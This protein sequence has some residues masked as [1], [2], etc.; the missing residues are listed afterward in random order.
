M[1]EIAIVTKIVKNTITVT[2]GVGVKVSS[3]GELEV[4][5]AAAGD[6]AY[7]V[8][9]STVVGDG[10]KT[11]QVALFCGGG[12]VPVKVS[13]GG[14]T[15]GGYAIAGTTGFEDKTLGGGTTV[16][17]IAGKFTQTGVSG[18]LV[19]LAVGQFAGVSS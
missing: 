7:G 11:V 3:N 17:Y 16:R 10:I 13:S 1:N 5:L 15:A 2:E 14:A 6:N 9:L 19:G 12:V 4:D 18:D 8:A